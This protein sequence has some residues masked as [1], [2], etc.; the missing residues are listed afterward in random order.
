MWRRILSILGALAV[1]G[2]FA[3][4]I[5]FMEGRYAKADDTK[6]NKVSI[7][8]NSLKDYI[9]W[10]QDQ[11]TYIKTRCGVRD[12]NKLPEH[13]YRNYIDY[14]NKKIELEKELNLEMQKKF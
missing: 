10:Y 1:L 5:Y 3:S 12:P 14:Q 4:G 11:M 9:R 6:Q 7:R 13:A 2:T 8:I